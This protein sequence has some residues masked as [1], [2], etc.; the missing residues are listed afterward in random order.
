MSSPIPNT[1]SASSE[2]SNAARHGARSPDNAHAEGQLPELFSQLFFTELADWSAEG[3]GE[4]IAAGRFLPDGGQ[5]LQADLPSDEALDELL[6]LDPE[7]LARLAEWLPTAGEQMDDI[8]GE[9]ADLR[10]WLTLALATAMPEKPGTD[11]A[12]A[13][14]VPGAR[15]PDAIIQQG[16]GAMAREMAWRAELA[17][18]GDQAVAD[19]AGLAQGRQELSL[20]GQLSDARPAAATAITNAQLQQLMR[21]AQ[22]SAKGQGEQVSGI[23]RAGDNAA[24]ESMLQGVLSGGQN[25][26]LLAGADRGMATPSLSL[27]TPMHQPQWSEE[28]GNRIRWMVS[29]RVQSA[30]LKINPPQLGPIEVRVSVNKDQ[31]S[32]SFMSQHA[33][34]RETLEDAIPRLRELM[35]S[36]GF[37]DVNVDVSQHSDT[38]QG[39]QESALRHADADEDSAGESTRAQ[40]RNI[41]S[42]IIDFY[43]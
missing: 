31:M 17:L 40:G 1:T 14:R 32:V 34:V 23:T 13:A 12:A 19:E 38:G 33:M 30:E 43:A 41:D 10:E 2:T 29:N 18:R 16:Q 21:L 6:D 11:S 28:V 8:P 39:D 27:A 15:P 5:L 7:I 36:Q 22:S 3:G 35:A 9:V 4:G 24:T 37:T 25:A 42:G 20:P 26:A